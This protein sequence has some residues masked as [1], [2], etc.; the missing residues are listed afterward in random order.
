LSRTGTAKHVKGEEERICVQCGA[1]ID[2]RQHPVVVGPH[3]MPDKPRIVIVDM[4]NGSVLADGRNINVPEEG[5]LSMLRAIEMADVLVTVD[6][7]GMWVKYGAEKGWVTLITTKSERQMN[8][9]KAAG[10]LAE[11]VKPNDDLERGDHPVKV[12]FARVWNHATKPTRTG[13]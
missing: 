12:K 5:Q 9:E 13:F 1:E 6:D 7:T 4:R 10:E 3:L 8:A 11:R 2:A